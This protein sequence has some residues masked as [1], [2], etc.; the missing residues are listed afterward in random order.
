MF[1]SS[2]LGA[3]ALLTAS[4]TAAPSAQL[5]TRADCKFDS[6]ASPD[7]WDGVFDLK[8]DYYTQGPKNDPKKPRV[9]DFTLSNV[10]TLAPDGVPRTVLAINGQIPGPTIYADWGD[11]VVVNVINALDYAGTA[12]HFHGI[13][14]N[15]TI[16]QDGVASITQCPI[17]GDGGKQT[18]TFVA[19][20]YGTSWYHSH[21]AVQAWDGVFGPIQIAGPASAPYHKDLGAVMLS[22]WTHQTSDSLLEAA[23]L[24]GGSVPMNNGLINGLNTHTKPGES[25]TGKRYEMV[26][27]KDKLH[28][29][30]F[31]NTAMD[32]MYKIS[33]DDHEMQV[34][35][36]DFV[37]IEPFTTKVLPIAIGQR[38]DVIVKASAGGGNH[39]FR[40]TPMNACGGGRD[41][42]VDVRAIVRYDAN[43]K[44][45][46]DEKD[47]STLPVI[48]DDCLDVPT[49]S[50]KPSAKIDLKDVPT[51]FQLDHNIDFEMNFDETTGAVDWRIKSQPYYSP[52]DYPTLQ[53]IVEGN[54]TYDP[55]QQLI[56]VDSKREWI[57]ALV[58]TSSGTTH[59]I[60]LHGH[61]FFILGQSDQEFNPDTFVPQTV[62]PPRR[63]VAMINGLG[64]IVI[65]FQTDNPGAWLLHCHIGWHT[66]QGFALTFMEHIDKVKGLVDSGPLLKQCSDWK[67]FAAEKKIK[68]HDS[69]V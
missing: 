26:F 30:R 10:T 3:A 61:D 28:R 8:T 62:N 36:A 11:T 69:G 52:W 47:P 50:L 14:Q 38:Y 21:Y 29:I 33:F 7:C 51:K 15:H 12:I 27:E 53:Q 54:T 41:E 55:R 60:H 4:V 57:Y 25:T 31:I 23:A 40:A 2:I 67:T 37:S 49:T 19:T 59:P 6:F 20:Q 18:Y 35:S 44:G 1:L 22:D 42:G 48:D 68:Q 32:T 5:G 56:H 45:T 66:S 58:R 17:P 46:P 39:W 64:Y 13:R 43:D 24:N 34:I 63:D 16:G 9:Y 65:A